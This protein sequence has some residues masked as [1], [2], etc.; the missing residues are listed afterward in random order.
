MN[1]AVRLSRANQ[2]QPAFAQIDLVAPAAQTAEVELVG[3][4]PEQALSVKR[5]GRIQLFGIIFLA[6]TA[7]GLFQA[8][9]ELFVSTAWRGVLLDKLFSSWVW[10]ALTPALV[11][12]DRK[13]APRQVSLVKSLTLLVLL[14]IPITL[15]NTLLTAVLLY[16][17]PEVWWSPFRDHEFTVFF[18]L[19]GWATYVALVGILQAYRFYNSYMTGQLQLE[20]VEKSLLESRLNALRLHLE[21]HFLFNTLNAIS[22]E[23]GENPQS[24]RNMIGD[25]GAL[26]RRSLDCQD[27]SEISLVEELSALEHYL[28]IQKIRFGDRIKI[29]VDVQPEVRAVM[30]PSMLLQPLVENAIRHGLEQRTSGGSITISA[31]KAGDELRLS[32]ADDGVGLPHGWRMESSTGHGLRIT[33]ERLV[34]SD[35]EAVEN[36]LSIGRGERGGTVAAIHIPLRRKDHHDQ[37]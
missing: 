15:L 25:L 8:V 33:L 34:A 29:D 32:V 31:T 17:F 28:S 30:V 21:P 4:P 24:A 16:P 11:W 36:C 10:A 3:T 23:V 2:Q 5:L 12:V 14:S 19:G 13:L 35:P 9:S 26:L 7:V 27:S 18:F 22:S 37:K 1:R 20:R 6:W